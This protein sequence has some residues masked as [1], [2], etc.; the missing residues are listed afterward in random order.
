MGVSDLGRTDYQDV[1]D[2]DAIFAVVNG[3]PPGR[4]RDDRVGYMA[5]AL[6]ETDRFCY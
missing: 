3:V 2:S 4:G 1:V 5:I 6:L